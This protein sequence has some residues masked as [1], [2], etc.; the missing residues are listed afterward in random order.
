MSDMASGLPAGIAAAVLI[1]T[2]ADD[3]SRASSELSVRNR[4]GPASIWMMI[5]TVDRYPL[6]TEPVV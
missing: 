3:V 5:R 4:S 1:R 6:S 2:A